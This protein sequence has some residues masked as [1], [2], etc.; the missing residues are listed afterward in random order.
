[1][2]QLNPFNLIRNAANSLWGIASSLPLP[3]EI[4]DDTDEQEKSGVFRNEEQKSELFLPPDT[5]RCIPTISGDAAS[6]D[7]QDVGHSF[8]FPTD[9]TDS[10]DVHPS[11]PSPSL[12]DGD[13][14]TKPNSVHARPVTIGNDS[15]VRHGKEGSGGNDLQDDQAVAVS[16]SKYS[17]AGVSDSEQCDPTAMD[18]MDV[19]VDQTN[20]SQSDCPTLCNVVSVSFESTTNDHHDST[21]C[22]EKIGK[23]DD[24]V[25]STA[26]GN[27][28]IKRRNLLRLQ[29]RRT[30]VVRRRRRLKKNRQQKTPTNTA[31]AVANRATVAAV[32]AVTAATTGEEVMCPETWAILNYELFP[33]KKMMIFH[34]TLVAMMW[35]CLQLIRVPLRNAETYRPSVQSTQDF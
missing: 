2:M 34:R 15:V 19:D 30:R 17:G 9:V 29:R 22:F 20:E 28:G 33:W 25:P 13:G 8:L 1:M 23:N 18:E 3:L 31:A 32:T 24:N 14:P 26:V 6:N 7:E 27:S 4:A 16:F 10:F 5:T 21:E 12:G 11:S 35:I